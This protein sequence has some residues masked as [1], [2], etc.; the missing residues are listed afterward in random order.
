MTH[1]DTI[2]EIDPARLYSGQTVDRIFDINASTRWRWVQRGLLTARHLGGQGS[3][4]KFLGRELLDL[5][6]NSARPR[7]RLG[8]HQ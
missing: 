4:P 7:Q 3:R 2:G 1:V 8:T 5:I 6:E